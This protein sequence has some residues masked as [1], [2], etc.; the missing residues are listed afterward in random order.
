MSKVNIVFKA[1]VKMGLEKQ[2]YKTALELMNS[3]KAEE[4]GCLQFTFH[5]H[6]ENPNLFLAYEQYEDSAAM[7][8]HFKRL[9]KVYGIP[10]DGENLPPKLYDFFENIEFDFY[11]I[12]E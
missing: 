6:A 3:T 5:Q 4:V 8:I 2:F 9:E 10:R 11:N 1:T 7:N 12:V